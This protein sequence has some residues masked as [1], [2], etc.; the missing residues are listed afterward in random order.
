MQNPTFAHSAGLDVHKKS[1][2]AAVIS[3]YDEKGRE[4]YETHSFGTTTHDIL[5][6][7]AWLEERGIDH[8][9]LESTGEYWKPIYNLLEGVFTL[10]VVN[11]C[12]VK[13]VPGRKTDVNDAQWLA[14]LMTAGLLNPSF[15]PPPGLRELRE[16]TRARTGMV[17]ERTNLINRVHKTLESTNIKLTSVVSDIR[18]V[19]ARAMLSALLAGETD[20]ARVADLAGPRLKATREELERALQGR[21]QATHR[22]ILTELL[23]QIDAVDASIARFDQA[24]EQLCRPF[25]AAVAHADTIP[26][27]GAMA[28]RSIISEI[29]CD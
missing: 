4:L 14:K 29:G 1:V 9:A 18:G 28:A 24:I 2:V 11:A 6:M 19:S 8:V 3:G 13:H 20:P 21:M 7:A 15:V 12:H 5:E 25:E 17:R 22:F 10:F 26:G 16:L 23:T 27:V